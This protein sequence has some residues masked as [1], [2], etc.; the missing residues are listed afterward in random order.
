MQDLSASIKNLLLAFCVSAT[1][2]SAQAQWVSIP[3]TNFGKWLN[4]NGYNMC[5]QGNSTVGWQMDTTCNEV[6]S[7]TSI[8]CQYQNIIDLEGIQYFDSLVYLGCIY[9]QLTTLPSLP[10]TLDT[11]N[12]SYNQISVL[13]ILPNSLKDLAISNNNLS[14]LPLLPDSLTHLHIPFNQIDSIKKLPPNLLAISCGQ[15]PLKYIPDTLP[16][17]LGF[18][19]TSYSQLRQLPALPLSLKMLLCSN[20]QLETLPDLPKG[21]VALTAH[22]N[23]LT[24]LPDMPDSLSTLWMNDNPFLKCL[25]KLNIVRDIKLLNTG[26]NCLPNY[27]SGNLYTDLPLNSIPLCD[28][29]FDCNSYLNVRGKVMSNIPNDCSSD[30]LG[31]VAGLI[32]LNLYSGDT[33]VQQTFST[34]SGYFSFNVPTQ[35]YEVLIDTSNTLYEVYCPASEVDT[36]FL[37]G[38]NPVDTSLLFGIR[39][40]NGFD[41]GVASAVRQ[42]GILRPTFTSI[43]KIVAGDLGKIHGLNC[44]TGVSGKITVVFSGPATFAGIAAGSLNP[45]VSGNTL[46]YSVPDFEALDINTAFGLKF[47]IDTF[48]QMGE[49]LCL[50]ITVL[51]DV[52]GDINNTNNTLRICF[53][54]LNS[55][56]PNMKEV[57]PVN[58]IAPTE[59]WLTY[60]IH[61]QNMGNAPAIH[62]YVMDTLDN[63]LDESSIQI[64]GSSHRMLT[65]IKGNIARFN[66]PNINLV[67]SATNQPE[68]KG[69]LQYKIKKNTGLALGTQIKNTASIY[70]DFNAP[71]V[72]NTVTNTVEQPN[73]VKESREQMS[74]ISVFPNPTN[75]VVYISYNSNTS[76]DVTLF[77][78]NGA[79]CL[80]QQLTASNQSIS[81]SGLPA[82]VYFVSVEVEGNVVRKKVVKW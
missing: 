22:N 11:L 2:F 8:D 10:S 12:C 17:N 43:F 53:E 82:G 29:P 16:P 20:N 77:N 25:P 24:S 33:L 47:L 67:D 73:A 41:V 36:V 52:A 75:D 42:S 76:A 13:P 65:E 57:S 44:S 58:S 48:A 51:P 71:V 23:Q 59:D 15:N 28:I 14:F 61:F 81:L 62:I 40:K 54:V 69:W 38:A 3:D 79:A 30:T 46:T 4:T 64:L 1:A 68:S 55:Y 70:F 56:D 35:Q 5:L 74:E 49:Q 6:V 39:C 31:I 26:I 27:P 9:N 78:I 63:K 21:L 7:A 80:K 50:S 18:L 19:V 37:S 72:T 32:K 60:T 34:N 45:T 66:F